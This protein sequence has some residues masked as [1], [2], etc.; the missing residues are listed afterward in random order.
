MG[1]HISHK[2]PD[3]QQFANWKG[4]T[5]S[6]KTHRQ[7]Y[8]DWAMLCWDPQEPNFFIVGYCRNRRQIAIWAYS[9]V[10]I[11]VSRDA[12][13]LVLECLQGS[14]DNWIQICFFFLR[15]ERREW[16]GMGVAGIIIIPS[17][18]T[19]STRKKLNGPPIL[20]TALILLRAMDAPDAQ[21]TYWT[22][23]ISRRRWDWIHRLDLGYEEHIMVFN[24]DFG[25]RG[26]QL[27]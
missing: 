13:A 27:G 8:L 25:L 11:A 22:D 3:V 23:V 17:F 20:K 1:G 9:N 14:P 4:L 16:M 5:N 10:S 2:P 7:K 24:L 6:N 18:P 19:F 26:T 21:G 15:A 12:L